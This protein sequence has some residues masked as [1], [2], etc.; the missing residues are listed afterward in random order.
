MT[1][2]IYIWKVLL[3]DNHF[4]IG[5]KI[6]SDFYVCMTCAAG[7]LSD[8]FGHKIADL[9]EKT[10]FSVPKRFILEIKEG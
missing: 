1:K 2:E 3:D 5:K 4:L 8:L 10:H 7:A 9:V 6:D